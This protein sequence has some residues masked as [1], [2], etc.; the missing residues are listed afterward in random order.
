MPVT[1]LG[2]SG[3][4]GRHLASA[5]RARGVEPWCPDREATEQIYRRPLGTVYYCIGLTADFLARPFDTVD[6]H[7]SLLASIL[8]QSDFERLVYLSSTRLYDPMGAALAQESTPLQCSPGDPRHLY[9]LS[10][11]LGE[12]LCLTVS[13]GRAKV[14]RLSCVLGTSLEDDGFVPALVRDGRQ[15]KKLVVQSS[16]HFSR[17][18]VGID[19]VTT[20]L[21]DIAE[22]GRQ[23]IYNVASGINVSNRELFGIVERETGCE[24]HAALSGQGDA[25]AVDVTR[26]RDEFGFHPTPLKSL[27]DAMLRN[28]PKPSP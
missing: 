17:D 15:T 19:D 9:N 18:Y 8:K 3:F 28:A 16:P 6:A 25:P 1:I 2:A 27:I 11:G 14:A 22:R 5:L 20:L 23:D 24:I 26:I 7:V 4:I 13:G 10:K 12:N 21:M